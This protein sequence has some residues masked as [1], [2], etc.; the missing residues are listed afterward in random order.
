MNCQTCRFFSATLSDASSLR[1]RDGI[2]EC[3]RYAP[4]GPLTYAWGGQG[5]PEH[6]HVAVMSPF[7]FVPLDDW[8][9]D[10]QPKK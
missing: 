4:R 2:G 7:P 10:Y 5:E 3:R 1:Y 6:Q 8:C 9:G